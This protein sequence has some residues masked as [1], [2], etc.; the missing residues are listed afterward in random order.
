MAKPFDRLKAMFCMQRRLGWLVGVVLP[1]CLAFFCCL[2]VF[3][4]ILLAYRVFPEVG[5]V[6]NSQCSNPT[7]SWNGKIFDLQVSSCPSIHTNTDM[8][9]NC[10]H[11]D[12]CHIHR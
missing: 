11:R 10:L 9:T 5:M 4:T 12:S 2:S 3:S 7:P 6:V 8:D 1:A